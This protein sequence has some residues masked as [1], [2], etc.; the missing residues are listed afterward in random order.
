MEYIDQILFR[1]VNP[2]DFKKLYDL[3]RPEGGGGQ[4]YLEAAGISNESL[5]EFLS[6]AEISDS[7][8]KGESR[9]IYTFN[10]YVLGD[11]NRNSAFIE[12]APRGGRNN[13]RI[14]R[15]NT[16][17]KHPAWKPSNG[18]PEPQKDLD[19]KYTSVGN[20]VGIID[21][22]SILILRT[23]YRKYYAG[24][25]NSSS[26]LDTWPRGIGLEQIFKG[27]RRGVLDISAAQVE[28]CNS[29][30]APF[31]QVHAETAN[32][33]ASRIGNGSNILLYGVPGAGKSWAIEHEYCSPETIVE[34]VVFH[35]DYTNSDFV[36]QILPIVDPESKQITYEFKPG[37]FTNILQ[38]A[39]QNPSQR[40]VLIIEEINRGN[41]PAIFGDLFQLLDRTTEPQTINGELCPAGTSEYGITNENIAA[42]VYENCAHKVRI[43][44]NLSLFGTMNTSDQNVFT[45]DTAFQRRWQMH[46][47][48]NN[49]D[50]VLPSF[51]NAIIL[52][53]QVTW[54]KF[55]ETVNH[56]IL[57]G[58][59]RMA[60][61]EDKRL[62]V[63]FVHAQDLKID[64]HMHPGEG[65][66]TL[67]DEA[68]DLIQKELHGTLSSEDGA[69]LA[70]I[71]TILIHNRI[72]PEKVLKYL[73]DDA[74]K[75]DPSMLFDTDKMESLEQVIRT[76]T[77]NTG[78][79]RFT[80]FT[81]EVQRLLYADNT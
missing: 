75:F 15:Q 55:C 73:W 80:V 38:M 52:D 33:P 60:S 76:F 26:L 40:Y 58:K 3:D 7:P 39:Y 45:L 72:F 81:P 53:T 41:A 70:Q 20:F 36:G 2:S 23:T 35:P 29:L 21:D 51:S 46:L 50:H 17:Y 34:R 66:S 25:I 18:F 57:Q 14:S 5:K 42:V 22:L 6:Y 8:L 68:D 11:P 10:A 44:S 62:G 32:A 1:K 16:R 65:Y 27:D 78:R 31:G 71:R 74:F 24:Y 37:P 47:I 77:Y 54:R 12:F 61:A 59:S 9:V 13:Y 69:R 28:F 19:G 4:T 63:Y 48:E 56:I 79:G 49:F 30:S 64:E 67:A 43:P